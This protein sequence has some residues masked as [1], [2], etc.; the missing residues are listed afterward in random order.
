MFKTDLLNYINK[1][2]IQKYIFTYFLLITLFSKANSEVIARVIKLE[3]GAQLRSLS[4]DYFNEIVRPGLP[5][6]NGDAIKVN[7]K[8]FCIIM[9]VDDKSV[10]KIRENTQ[11]E[12]L[13]T[14]NTRTIELKYGTILNSV[15]SRNNI[16][17]FRVQTPVSVASVKGTEFA[18]TSMQNGID[19]FVCKKGS[20]E[21]LNMISGETVIVGPNQ[22]AVSN[23]SGSLMQSIAAP[24]DY[25]NENE[26][27]EN[28]LQN[29][30]NDIDE[31]TNDLIENDASDK[32]ESK[33]NAEKKDL[34]P[35]EPEKEIKIE[36]QDEDDILDEKKSVEESEPVAPNKPLS[37]GL[38]IGSAVIYGELYNQLAFRPEINLGKIGVGLD[39]IFYLDN[40]GKLK[41]N[42]WDIKNDP[43]LLFDKILYIKYG[44]KIDPFWFKYGS[45]ENMTL[46]YGGIINNYSNMMEFPSVRKVGANSGFS[47]GAFS[48]EIFLSNIKDISRGGTVNGLRISYTVSKNFP[49]SIGFNYILDGNM[50]SSMKDKDKDSYPDIFDDFPN[51][52][53]LWNDT[54]GDGWPDPGH[55]INI[56]DSLIDIDANNNNILDYEENYEDLRLKATPFSLKGNKAIS[57]GYSFDM[58]YPIFNNNIFELIIYTEFNRLN[59]PSISTTDSSFIRPQRDGTGLSIPGL[60]STLFKTLKLS[61]EYRI[62]S[63]FYVPQF[64]DQAYDLNRVVIQTIDDTTNIKTKDMLIFNEYNEMISSSG[65]YGSVDL[66][67]LNLANFSLSYADM[68]A[69]SIRL[70]NFDIALS[71]DTDNIPKINSAVAYY[72]RNNDSNPFDFANPNENTIMGYKIGYNISKGVNLIWNFRQY[73]RD[74]GTGN[75]ETIK[76][77][78]IE[79]A[80]NFDI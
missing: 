62:L 53:T 10:V 18:A 33:I 71:L 72:Q 34:I 5:I 27:D 55:G 23:L 44:M 3:G 47:I 8:G 37:M 54:D 69:D 75:V 45:I 79:T 52:S 50:F 39:L 24:S 26:F 43:S 29:Y 12:F 13:D 70:L 31:L 22:K 51:D 46:G 35:I 16:K 21:V 60:K 7:E 19:Q 6:K 20:F 64:F 73:Y 15:N 80:F 28:S 1:H 2:F 36:Y 11:F 32:P 4:N 48:G 41:I 66:N 40:E 61:F 25:P 77:T 63:G 14:K 30:Q 57:K 67:L 78:N 74:D 58:G 65:F 17:T 38:G 9:Y 76:Q 49:L 68:Q 42:E 56:A 59:F